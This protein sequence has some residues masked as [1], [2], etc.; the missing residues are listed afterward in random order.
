[1]TLF[2]YN[3]GS[4]DDQAQIA[5]LRNTENLPTPHQA[6]LVLYLLVIIQLVIV[7]LRVE[8]KVHAESGGRL[9]VVLWVYHEESYSEV[10]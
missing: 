2:S 3:E 5:E 6:H 8:L 10:L 9:K 7:Q 4:H 1:M